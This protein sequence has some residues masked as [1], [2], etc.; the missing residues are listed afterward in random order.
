MNLYP[1][2]MTPHYRHG[3]QTPWGG[4]A[5]REIFMKDAPEDLTGESL[6]VSTLEGQE[7]LVSNGPH[8]GKTLS[9][10]VELWSKDLTGTADGTFP[11]VL[12]LVDA[13]QNTS[14]QVHPDDAYAQA[15]ENMTGK[16]EAWVI[17]NAEPGAQLLSGLD[18]GGEALQ[19]LAAE[20]RIGECLRWQAARPGDVYYLPAGTVHALGA[21]IQIYE[22][23]TACD[24][25]FRLWDFDRNERPLHVAQALEVIKPNAVPQKNEGTTMLCKGGSRT[26]YVCDKAME[27]CRLNLSGT[28]PLESGKLLL[29]T[30]LGECELRWSGESLFLDPF[31]TVVIPASLEGVALVGNTKVLMAAP[32]DQQRLREALGYRAENVAGLMD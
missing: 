5:L 24:I 25:T 6:E 1:L 3:A 20:S 27:L 10:M 11:L 12:K 23:Q 4:Q 9:R 8:A 13:G 17:L 32:S 18:A 15:H 29:L 22:L 7:S 31:Q 28:M 2:I 26:Y 21:G 19:A 30:P 16:T 14:V